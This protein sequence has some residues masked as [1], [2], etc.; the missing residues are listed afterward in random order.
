[1][2]K[3]VVIPILLLTTLTSGLIVLDASEWYSDLYRP[4]EIFGFTFGSQGRGIIFAAILEAFLAISMS[5]RV[6]DASGVPHRTANRILV[7]LSVL[8][9]SVVG[10]GTY[11]GILERNQERFSGDANTLRQI[12]E[13]NAALAENKRNT[14]Y[15][16]SKNQPANLSSAVS[17]GKKLSDRLAALN[18]RTN[19][20]SGLVQE[21]LWFLRFAKFA[22]LSGNV[23]S[24][25][26]V[27]W[28]IRKKGTLAVEEG[29][30]K[31]VS[32]P[33]EPSP[34]PPLPVTPPAPMDVW[35]EVDKLNQTD[36]EKTQT[37][38]QARVKDQ[39]VKIPWPESRQVWRSVFRSSGFDS[40]ESVAKALQMEIPQFTA[41]VN[42]GF[43]VIPFLERYANAKKSAGQSL[44]SPSPITSTAGSSPSR[45][46]N[47]PVAIGDFGSSSGEQSKASVLGGHQ[48]SGTESKT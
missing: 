28:V 32:R 15:F 23:F 16:R 37:E 11:Q 43:K 1:M 40:W 8:L 17:E 33:A 34:L 6:Y 48:D 4:V 24:L 36:P 46:S 35:N 5:V 7:V 44:N 14:E 38:L 47:S 12:A 22:M 30:E 27:G 20:D 26:L 25:W 2:R 39:P 10:F 3:S 9:F 42:H 45:D 29:V 18:T 19:S 21:Q 13:V 31:K 41:V